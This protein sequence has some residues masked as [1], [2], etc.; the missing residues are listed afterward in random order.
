MPRAFC[1][2]THRQLVLFEADRDLNRLATIPEPLL[3]ELALALEAI[4]VEHGEAHGWTSDATG[5]VR[6]SLRL[7]LALQDT[8]GVPIKASEV[9]LLRHVTGRVGPTLDVLRAAQALEDDQIPTIVTWFETGVNPLPS[10]MRQ[11]LYLWFTIMREGSSQP[12]RSRP[13]ADR[14]IRNHL[15]FT[16]PVFKE[17]ARTHDSLREITRVEV[18]DTLIKAGGHRVDV[19]QGLRSTFRV[20]KAR[21]QIFTDPTSRIRSGMPPST[22]PVQQ[23]GS[24]LREALESADPAR[25]A[26]A[27]L[28]VFHGL[29]PRHL[30][31][32]LLTDVRD[33]RLHLDERVILLAAHVNTRIAA[34]LRYRAERWPNTVNPHLFITPMTAGR[35]T[36]VHYKWVNTTLGFR[37]QDLREDRILDEAH[38]SGGDTRRICDLFGLTTNAAQRYID[39]L[40]HPG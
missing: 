21:K 32:L 31:E 17:W 36:Q 11:E 29:R 1:L 12:P 3:P 7:L 14:T 34:Y 33:G 13:R 22:T 16:L 35:T 4:A 38:A 5:A 20:L 10:T 39:A 24:D 25:A 19:L 15:T 18:Q 6:R 8:P 26:L 2:A 37:A 30:R 28:L 23:K 40:H 27:G 9:H